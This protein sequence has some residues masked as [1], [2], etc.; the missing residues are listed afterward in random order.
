MKKLFF[1]FSFLLISISLSSCG[2]EENCRPRGGYAQQV[3]EGHQQMPVVAYHQQTEN[4][5]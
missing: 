1:V 5:K 4:I 3:I 2:A